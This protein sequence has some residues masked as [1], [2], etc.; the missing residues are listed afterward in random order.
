M[1]FF[2]RTRNYS[3]AD[4]LLVRPINEF[5]HPIAYKTHKVGVKM[6][7]DLTLAHRFIM[8]RLAVSILN[9]IDQLRAEVCI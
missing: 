2:P 7:K 6:V 9:I 8:Q 5:P 4:V 3:W 1:I